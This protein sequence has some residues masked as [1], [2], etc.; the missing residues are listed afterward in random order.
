MNKKIIVKLIDASFPS[1]FESKVQRLLDDGWIA[2]WPMGMSNFGKLYL[3][4]TK[5][6]DVDEQIPTD[7][8]ITK[9][10]PDAKKLGDKK[11]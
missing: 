4:M 2:H 11:K 3:P 10:H 9:Q 8:T 7:D 1:E 6:I 5:M